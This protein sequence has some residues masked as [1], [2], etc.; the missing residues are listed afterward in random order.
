MKNRLLTFLVK[1]DQWEAFK[2]SNSFVKRVELASQIKDISG[3]LLKNEFKNNLN[4]LEIQVIEE[5]LVIEN[6]PP[7]DEVKKEAV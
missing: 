2:N 7:L 3:T 4:N 1:E 5:H 6:L